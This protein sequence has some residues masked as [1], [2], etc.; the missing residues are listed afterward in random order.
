MAKGY[1]PFDRLAKKVNLT[2]CAFLLLATKSL[3]LLILPALLVML[4]TLHREH[5]DV[6]HRAKPSAGIS[7]RDAT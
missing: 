6:T 7:R 1:L 2:V 3:H 5:K 4:S